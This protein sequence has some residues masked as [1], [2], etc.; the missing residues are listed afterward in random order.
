MGGDA[1]RGLEAY[2]SVARYLAGLPDGWMSFPSCRAHRTVLASLRARGAFDDLER[3]PEPVARV[4]AREPDSEWIPEV[5]HI[6]M[7]LLFRDARFSGADGEEAFL[8]WMTDLRRQVMASAAHAS[9]FAVSKPEEVVAKLPE[10][11]SRFHQ[12]TSMR[13]EAAGPPARIVHWSPRGVFVPLWAAWTRR[14]FGIALAKGGA[15][16]PEVTF[17]MKHEGADTRTVFTLSWDSASRATGP[18]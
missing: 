1:Q 3:L 4:L 11:W 9:A 12:G 2:P 17:E 15:V 16:H 6:G 13:L 8:V 5:V 10:F 18:T 14:I 7:L